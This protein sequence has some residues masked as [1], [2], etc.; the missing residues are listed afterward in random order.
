MGRRKRRCEGCGA[1]GPITR[2]HVV[3]KR[4]L[5]VQPDRPAKPYL[6]R[7][8][9]PCHDDYE[10]YAQARCLELGEPV[11]LRAVQAARVLLRDFR[12]LGPLRARALRA[13]VALV[14]GRAPGLCDLLRMRNVRVAAYIF[15]QHDARAFA[16]AWIRHYQE[17]LSRR[18]RSLRQKPHGRAG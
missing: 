7:L 5:K 16:A 2:H 8:C 4:Y 17:W 14:L 15:A 1:G 9:R 12:A 6:A 13:R 3:P 11:V 18:R 10:T